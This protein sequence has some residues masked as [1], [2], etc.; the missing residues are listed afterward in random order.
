MKIKDK[1]R[2]T[3][4][5]KFVCSVYCTHRVPTPTPPFSTR[6][7]NAG[8]IGE[9]FSQTISN[10]GHAALLRRCELPPINEN[11]ELTQLIQYS[12]THCKD[13]ISKF[14]NKY[15]Q[16]GISGSQSQFPHSCDCERF[17]YFQNRSA[18]SAGGN[19]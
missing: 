5:F 14:R 2:A 13:K 6:G 8:R 16:K 7:G 17:I 11:D 1:S 4:N 15:Y 12:E 3:K 9:R 18:Y 19:M 10:L